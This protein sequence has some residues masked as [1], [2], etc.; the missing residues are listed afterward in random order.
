VLAL[1][2]EHFVVCYKRYLEIRMVGTTYAYDSLLLDKLLPSPS[3]F[4]I[5]IIKQTSGNLDFAI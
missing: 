4:A 3:V 5:F 2:F 1:N